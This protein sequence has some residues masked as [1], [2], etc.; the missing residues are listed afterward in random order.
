MPPR[1]TAPPKS[2][3]RSSLSR[4][5]RRDRVASR[6]RSAGRVQKTGLVLLCHV[7]LVCDVFPAPGHPFGIGWG[8]DNEDLRLT[9]GE[10]CHFATSSNTAR[11]ISILLCLCG[12]YRLPA[13]P[14][15]AKRTPRPKRQRH[16]HP[17]AHGHIRTYGAMG[18][19]RLGLG[20]S[21]LADLQ[22]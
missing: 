16:R 6:A 19:A 5:A 9:P 2:S 1:R 20:L 10:D 12:S 17:T 15:R 14:P 21:P 13:S 22:S 7:W 18:L 11:G 8:A 3:N 4:K